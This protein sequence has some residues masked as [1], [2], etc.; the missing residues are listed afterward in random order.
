MLSR[1]LGSASLD[2]RPCR[3][4]R[5]WLVPCF[6]ERLG[7]HRYLRWV[8][9]SIV[10]SGW[11]I[12]ANRVPFLDRFAL[13]R[14]LAAVAVLGLLALIPV[15]QFWRRPGNLLASSLIAWLILSLSYRILSMDFSDLEER[16]SAAQIFVLG[17][18]V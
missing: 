2:V 11:V 17:V 18:V 6:S 5:V 4:A 14:N 8:S 13:A 1:I 12:V 3:H 10:F 9:L 16:F 15:L 7:A